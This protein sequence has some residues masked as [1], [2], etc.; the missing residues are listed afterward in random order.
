MTEWHHVEIDGGTLTGSTITDFRGTRAVPYLVDSTYYFV[1]VVESDGGH[2]CM[3]GGRSLQEARV[4]AKE[5]A[6][7]FGVVV[8]DRTGGGKP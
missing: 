3:W 4:V 7:D 1:D 5:C 8:V 2:L 6:A